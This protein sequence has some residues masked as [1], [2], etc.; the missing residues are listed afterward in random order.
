[1]KEHFIVGADGVKTFVLE[2]PSIGDETGPAIICLHGLS[3]NHRDFENIFEFLQN[4]GR[5][6]FAFDIRGRGKSDWDRNPIN[7]NPLTYF[8]DVT[9]ACGQLAIEKAVFIGT[10]MG[11]IIS[12]LIGAYSPQLVAG[13]VLNDVGPEVAQEGIERIK[14]YIGKDTKFENWESAAIAIKEIGISAFPEK[15]SDDGF[16]QDFAQKTCIETVNGIIFN[17]DPAIKQGLAPQE[18]T[19]TAAP[20]LWPQFELLKGLSIVLVRGA[21]SDI[22]STEIVKKMKA[23]KPDMGVYEVPRVGH[24]PILD[25]EVSLQAISQILEV[26]ATTA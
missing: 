15:S 4:A 1:M 12:M 22:L 20:T 5:R 14:S 26:T 23:I 11:G 25:E 6:V 16:W 17:Y 13:I 24:A 3:R 7:Y 19:S 2:L 18:D 8:Q 9:N 21:L 10:S